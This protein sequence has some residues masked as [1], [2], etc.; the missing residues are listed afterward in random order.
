[1]LAELA[2]VST[3]EH[4]TAEDGINWYL[5]VGLLSESSRLLLVVPWNLHA[6][7]SHPEILLEVEEVIIWQVGEVLS[8]HIFL[9]FQV[10]L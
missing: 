5:R 4:S 1:L 3:R 7:P 8:T 9:E 6:C 2:P 10:F